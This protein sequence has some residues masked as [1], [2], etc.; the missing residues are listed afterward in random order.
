MAQLL[1]I[2]LSN[3]RVEVFSRVLIHK[4]TNL[5]RQ[6]LEFSISYQEKN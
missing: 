6:I 4:S 1:Q 5:L 2:M 3:G